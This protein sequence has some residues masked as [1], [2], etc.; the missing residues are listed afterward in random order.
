MT[1]LRERRG[2]WRP[3]V[4]LPLKLRMSNWAAPSPVTPRMA[5]DEP[6]ARVLRNV[7]GKSEVRRPL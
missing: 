2:Y 6:P 7:T 5:R 3:I 1:A 4:T